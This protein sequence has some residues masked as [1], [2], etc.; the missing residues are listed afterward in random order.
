M[1]TVL[2]DAPD[3][4]LKRIQIAKLGDFKDNRYGEFSITTDNVA[5]WQKNLSKLPGG[6]AL[7]D[8]EH[9]SE[10]KPRDSKAA[11][12]ISAIELDGKKVMADVSWTPGG[13]QAIKDREYRFLS[14]VYGPQSLENGEVLDDALPSVALTNKP[15]LG[16]MPALSLASEERLSAA[17]DADPA[18]RFYTR[19]LDGELGELAEA[20]VMLDVNQAER[21]KAK[22]AGNSVGDS[23]PINNV[24]QL[25]A[26]AIL[27][28]SKHGNWKAAQTLIK[29]R[30][31]ELGVALNTLAGFADTAPA[32]TLDSRAPMDKQLLTALGLDTDDE[33]VKTLE[34]F[35]LDETASKKILD[36]ATALK[37]KAD[38]PAEPATT[39][40]ADVKTLEQQATE[41]GKRLL[42]ADEFK[43]LERQAAA[44]QAAMDRL[45]QQAFDH[46]FDQAVEA[47]K[48][49]P[50]ERD[51][52]Q[53]FYKLDAEATLKALDDRQP[54]VPERPLGAPAI[55]LDQNGNA[56]PQA[57]VANG[58]HPGNH[59]L[60]GQ[61]KKYL[62]DNK[63]PEN[64]YAKVMEQYVSG[65]IAL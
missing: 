1:F 42:D 37:D 39:E 22:A 55:E 43:T 15:F 35:E 8:F 52:L 17:I 31:K 7:I 48:V 61:I 10:R 38:K 50:A 30:A 46:A 56:D 53:H 64:D 3:T 12:W 13:E 25:K 59:S 62:L 41:N 27:A 2:L 23:Y 54:I 44:G 47:R 45:H 16:S 33:L 5:N 14:P 51:G 11:G 18:A 4:P 9:R 24:K 21:D 65:R 40:T 32:K 57:L 6:E 26:A 20:L 34:A 63:L 58:I 60:D 29:R 49:A 19:A 36:A 28:A